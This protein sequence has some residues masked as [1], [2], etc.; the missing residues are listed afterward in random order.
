MDGV[1]GSLAG[2]IFGGLHHSSDAEYRH[3]L[4]WKEGG[5]ETEG[6]DEED[7]KA[8]P[9][10]QSRMRN[11]EWGGRVVL[12]QVTTAGFLPMRP[13]KVLLSHT[14]CSSVCD[15]AR[16]STVRAWAAV[17]AASFGPCHAHQPW[18]AP[19]LLRSWCS[20]VQA[21][22]CQR[23]PRGRCKTENER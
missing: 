5:R 20:L 3:V 9:T 23:D 1:V 4:G 2:S 7:S 10:L 18:L 12:R 15:E 13:I 17:L 8:A 22:E 11:G 19:L 16:G 6:Q 14:L 21:S